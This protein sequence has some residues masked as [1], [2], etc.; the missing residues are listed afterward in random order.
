MSVTRRDASRK[1][2]KLP[3]LNDSRRREERLI[4]RYGGRHGITFNLVPSTQHVIVRSS[5]R[6]PILTPKRPFEV[7]PLTLEARAMLDQYQLEF[8]LPMV[9][10]EVLTPRRASLS[11][12]ER[13]A[14]IKVLNREEHIEFAAPVLIDPQG[15]RPVIYTENIF[16]K[17]GD[18]ETL[19]TCT[20]ILTRYKLE[21]LRKLSYARNAWFVAARRKGLGV[22]G[23]AEQLLNEPQ[24][25]LCHPELIRE[26]RQRRVFP[27]QWHLSKTKIGDMTIDAHIEVEAAWK[28]TRGKGAVIAVIDNGFDVDHEEFQ[29]AK[30]K[31]VWPR[32]VTRGSDDPRPGNSDH[33]GTACAGVA[34]AN[35]GIGASGVAPDAKLMPIRLAP[36][37]GSQAEAEAFVWA[38]DHGADVISCS[39]GPLDGDWSNPDDPLHQ[40]VVLLPD[41]TRLAIEYAA[42]NGRKGKGWVIVFA[43]GNGNES[44]DNDGYASYEHV[45]AVAACNDSGKRSVYSDHGKAIGCTFPSNDVAMAKPLTPG[46][47]TTDRSGAAG[48]NPGDVAKGDAKGNYTNSFGGTSSA[49]AGVA[50]AAA[51]IV[52]ANPSLTREQVRDLLCTTCD[53]IDVEEGE[54]DA[55]GR[56]VLYGYGRVNAAKALK[57]AAPKKRKRSSKKRR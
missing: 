38:A 54:Y 31:I 15:K 24:V 1:S 35:G 28:V 20:T 4:V 21:I 50:G 23:I 43:A 53:R 11:A 5:P 19:S 33:H 41:S 47:W 57:L 25:E 30:S 8:R 12:A 6:L 22:F 32:D 17:F 56:S 44:V 10:V 48:Y 40:Q 2:I 34:C 9:G 45:I 52:A 14:M 39:W 55:M 27:Q 7:T 26:S 3:V 49:A 36:F 18:E 29:P 13:D 37:L 46:I 16:V 42:M 51:L